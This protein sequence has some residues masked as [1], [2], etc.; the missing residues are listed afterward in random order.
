MENDTTS[1]PMSASRMAKACGLP[2]LEYVTTKTGI[3]RQTLIDWHRTRP[4]L[5]SVILAGCA[6]IHEDEKATGSTLV[7]KMP[8][9]PANG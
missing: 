8:E 2:N 4:L 3:S 6:A 9:E 5:W 1:K 7:P